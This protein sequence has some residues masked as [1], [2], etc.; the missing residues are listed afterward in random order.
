MRNTF[1]L[2]LLAGL[3]LFP[4]SAYTQLTES[5]RL[6]L[7]GAKNILEA[8]EAR[9]AQDNWTVAIAIVDAGGHLLAF[10]RIDG[11]QIGSIEVALNK[12]KASVFYKRPTKAFQDGLQGGN[13]GLLTLPGFIAFE[14]GVPIEHNGEIIGAVG[15]SGVTAAQDGIIAN[16]GIAALSR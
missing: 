13:T 3:L 9:A 5:N 10:S 6:T 4:S 2:I 16:A 11:T 12:A 15:V 7:E 1:F 14:G 8:A